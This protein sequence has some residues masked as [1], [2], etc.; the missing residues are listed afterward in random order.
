MLLLV[1]IAA[2]AVVLLL[3]SKWWV[4]G[5]ISGVEFFLL[6]VVYGGLGFGLFALLSKKAFGAAVFVLLA[7]IAS[8]C[9]AV[10]CNQKLGI[11]HYYLEKIK[12]YE[13]AIQADP[14]NVAARGMLSEAYY[15]IGNLDQA[16][17]G[18]ELAVQMSPKAIAENRRLRDWRNE[19][20]LRDSKTV[21]CPNCN[22]RNLWGA[23]T[24]RTCLQPLLYHN[25]DKTSFMDLI[26]KYS[27]YISVA[28][29]WLIVVA[30]SFSVLKPVSGAVVS[31]CSALAV[32]GMML[33]SSAKK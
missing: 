19:R 4:D 17:A 5:L 32:I 6:T 31:G 12:E 24:C 11:K 25:A 7:I 29:C 2:A 18:M 15:M 13:K 10:Y 23:T 28:S 33:L 1:G 21:V 26:S 9:W 8:V 14:H 27:T 22:S 3:T 16:I 30:I 20:E